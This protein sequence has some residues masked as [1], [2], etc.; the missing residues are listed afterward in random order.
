MTV[1]T[2]STVNVVLQEG[3]KTLDEVVVVA[4]GNAKDIFIRSLNSLEDGPY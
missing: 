1:G 4:N 2:A 3:G